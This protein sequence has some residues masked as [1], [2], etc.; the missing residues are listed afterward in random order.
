MAVT[1]QEPYF[2]PIT[3]QPTTHARIAHARNWLSGGTALASSTHADFFANG[4]LNA[5]TYEK[6]KPTGSTSETW[7]YNHGSSAACDYCCIAGHDMATQGASY[8]VQ[9]YDGSA[10]QDLTPV[11]AAADDDAIMCIFAPITAQ[12][13][14]VEIT[15]GDAASTLSVVR[16]G[17]ALQMPRPIYG[18]V[19]PITYGRN[20][21][22]QTNQSETGDWLGRYPQRRSLA[23]GFSWQHI[24]HSW[25]IEHWPD[26][27]RAIEG[28]PVFIAW[29]PQPYGDVGYCW[30]DGIP[31]FETMGISNLCSVSMS[32]KGYLSA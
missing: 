20:V 11:T 4:P 15:G 30:I 3:D 9:Y 27:Q 1:L 23:A 10:W 5:L 22:M 7:E 14:R 25:F 8:Q 17:V 12:R 19:T 6:W 31:A 32:V 24:K 18:G 28:D 29:R 2:M 26:F 16:F 13:W 21:E